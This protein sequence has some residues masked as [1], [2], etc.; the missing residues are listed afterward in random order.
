[1]YTEAGK[2]TQRAR[3]N[4]GGSDQI[5]AGE[6]QKLVKCGIRKTVWRND[7]CG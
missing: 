4:A 7:D 3:D 2:S 5:L 1:M 6:K